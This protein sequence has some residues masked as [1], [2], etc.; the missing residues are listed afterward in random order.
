VSASIDR[1][2]IDVRRGNREG[3]GD[4]GFVVVDEGDSCSG[5][6]SGAEA[7][8]A[9]EEVARRDPPVAM[10]VSDHRMPHIFDARA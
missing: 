5:T 3:R 10:I 9:L 2:H 8:S 1:D 6:A 7:L 4:Y